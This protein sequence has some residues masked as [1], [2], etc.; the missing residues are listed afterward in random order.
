[1]IF[2]LID[3]FDGRKPTVFTYRF[4]VEG[5]GIAPF[6]VGIVPDSN[7]VSNLHQLVTDESGTFTTTARGQSTRRLLKKLAQHSLKGWDFNPFF[8]LIEAFSKK[9]FDAT[10]PFARSYAES[11]LKIQTMDDEL[12]LRSG[13]IVSD[14]EK[15]Q[16][17]SGNFQTASHNLTK[18]IG[19]IA[20]LFSAPEEVLATYATLLK[21]GLTGLEKSDSFRKVEKVLEFLHNDL[22]VLLMREAVLSCLHF[23]GKSG[24]LIPLQSGAKEVRRKLLASAWDLFLLRLPEHLIANETNEVTSIYYICTAEKALQKVGRMFVVR[25]VSSIREGRGH[26]PPSVGFKYNQL[27]QEVGNR[28]TMQLYNAY[29]QRLSNATERTPRSLAEISQIVENLEG[30]ASKIASLD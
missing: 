20:G 25:R 1:M 30:Q 15:L 26:V 16:P 2:T 10:F 29:A 27:S 7:V 19:E 28:L 13:K 9:G 3:S 5:Y 22:G 23:E 17:G 21:I 14:P 24:R 4:L 12:Y 8:Y 6:L 11:V 18:G